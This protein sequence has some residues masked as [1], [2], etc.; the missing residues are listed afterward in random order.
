MPDSSERFE[1]IEQFQNLAKAFKEL[2]EFC[3]QQAEKSNSIFSTPT[4]LKKDL[5]YNKRLGKKEFAMFKLENPSVGEDDVFLANFQKVKRDRRVNCSAKISSILLMEN[6][7][8]AQQ[9][10]LECID[11]LKAECG[12]I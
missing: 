11:N 8:S 6:Y 12:R 9:K 10:I 5:R 3:R 2:S 7:S 1:T 4:I